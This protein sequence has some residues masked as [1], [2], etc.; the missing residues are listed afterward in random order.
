MCPDPEFPN[1]LHSEFMNMPNVE[2]LIVPLCS[3][4]VS[5][6]AANGVIRCGTGT[7]QRIGDCSEHAVLATDA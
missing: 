4:P 2:F 5:Y 3:A 6:L 7:P 1:A